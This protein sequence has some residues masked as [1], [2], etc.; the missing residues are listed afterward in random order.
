[1]V[2]EFEDIYKTELIPQQVGVRVKFAAELLA[3][4]LRMTLH[5][6]ETFVLISIDLTNAYNAM[7]RATVFEAHLMH[8]KLRR[9]DPYRRAESGPHSPVW[10]CAEEFWG[11]DGLNQGTPSSSSGF[12]WTIHGRVRQ[13]NE[14]LH[15]YGGCARFGINDGHMVGPRDVIF[16]ILSEF[17]EGLERDT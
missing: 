15:A 9:S 2:K 3:M 5:V 10:A 7:K 13:T 8:D 14:R 11:E 4:G 16:T 1:M 12:S 6:H 17:A